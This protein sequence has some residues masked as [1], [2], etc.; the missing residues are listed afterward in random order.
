MGTCVRQRACHTPTGLPQ[1]LPGLGRM[2]ER[3]GGC[4]PPS[5]ACLEHRRSAHGGAARHDTSPLP[6]S[7]RGAS[8][9]LTPVMRVALPFLAAALRSG[10]RVLVHCDR[11]ASRSASVVIAHLMQHPVKQVLNK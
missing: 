8:A 9:D 10:G 1:R 2:C 3:G 4:E 11:G 5:V 6:R 7:G